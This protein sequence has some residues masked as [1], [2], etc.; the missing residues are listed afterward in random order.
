MPFDKNNFAKG[1]KYGVGKMPIKK[2]G[3][4]EKEVMRAMKEKIVKKTKNK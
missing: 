3:I 2:K 4:P 1:M